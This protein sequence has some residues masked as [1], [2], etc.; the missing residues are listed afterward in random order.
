[1]YINSRVLY[2]VCCES[3]L[4][5]AGSRRSF[6]RSKKDRVKRKKCEA[7]TEN[8]D[9]SYLEVMPYV[10]QPGEPHRLVLLVGPAGVGV[11]EL[12]RK[13]FLSDPEHAVPQAREQE[14]QLYEA[15]QIAVEAQELLGLPPGAKSSDSLNLTLL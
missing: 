12:K 1:M 9:S 8:H 15:K 13:L 4:H 2:D 10:R 6:R 14:S 3:S 5:L 11:T 7:E